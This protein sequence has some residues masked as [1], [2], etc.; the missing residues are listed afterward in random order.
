MDA[1]VTLI[2]LCLVVAHVA[3][4]VGRIVWGLVSDRLIQDSRITCLVV[5]GISGASGI[6]LLMSAV[7]FGAAGIATAAAL[8]GFTLGGYAG[9]TQTAAVEAVE[10]E[11]AGASIGYTCCLLVLVRW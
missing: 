8:V 9:L 2:T 5:I 6:G 1:T 11:Q 7:T 3:S 4:A 10:P